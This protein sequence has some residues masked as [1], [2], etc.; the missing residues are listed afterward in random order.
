MLSRICSVFVIV[1]SKKVASLLSCPVFDARFQYD[2][3]DKV[4]VG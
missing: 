3:N 2:R 1:S 4:E